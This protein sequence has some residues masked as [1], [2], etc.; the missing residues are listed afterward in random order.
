ME[1]ITFSIQDNVAQL[2]RKKADHDRRSLSAYIS[3]LIE[4]DAASLTECEAKAE[5]LA[6]AEEVGMTRALSAVV[7]AKRNRRK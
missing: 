6:A 3:L 7:A 4:R 5:L 2:A 1:R